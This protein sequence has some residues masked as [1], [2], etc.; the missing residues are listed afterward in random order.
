[1][2]KASYYDK[3]Q[4][5]GYVFILPTL[6]FFSIFLIFP[7][8]DSF[9]LSLFKWNLIGPKT[10]VGFKNF[11]KLFKGGRFQ[12]SYLVTLHFTFL[13][14][15]I[16]TF[17]SFWLSV[18]LT[19]RLIRFRNVLQSMIFLPVVLSMVAIAIVW[20]FMFQ[21][22]G[23]LSV[24]FVNIF[25][26]NISWLTSTRIAP[27]SMIIVNVW[28]YTGY[29]MVMFIAG[30]LDIPQAYYEAAK[31]DGAGFWGRLIYITIPSFVQQRIR[32]VL[33]DN[34][35]FFINLADDPE[36]VN[37]ESTC[38]ICF[39][40]GEHGIV[41][42]PSCDTVAHDLCW[43]QWAKTSNIGIPHVYRCHNCFNILKLDNTFISDVQSGKIQSIAELNKV[44]KKNIVEYLR[45]L[46][47]KAELKVVHTEDPFAADVRAMLEAKKTEPQEEKGKK[48]KRKKKKALVKICPNC[49]KLIMGDKKVCPTC[50]F[51]LF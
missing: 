26:L 32:M 22:T 23:L 49:S 51:S 25:G 33:K 24:I 41:R 44:K 6:V 34:Q 7:M 39:Q 19:S 14:V 37:E 11:L 8:L 47:A 21:T 46:E 16:I 15:I 48:K 30:L 18:A 28:R 42:C 5:W 35:P 50:G 36:L 20:Q 13:S 10:F 29:Y 3:L 9:R 45:E 40:K 1:M 4:R 17:I 27:Y 38:S 43:A 31:I 2:R 12:N